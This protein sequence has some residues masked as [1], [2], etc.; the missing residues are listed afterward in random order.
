MDA[1]LPVIA[2]SSMVKVPLLTYTPP[3]K[4]LEV[5]PEIVPPCMVNSAP[6]PV[7]YTP[8][9]LPLA[10]LFEEI[11]PPVMVKVLPGLAVTTP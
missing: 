8:P 4:S 6:L 1:V 5:F 10:L 7:I 3:P 9:P 2:P 11:A